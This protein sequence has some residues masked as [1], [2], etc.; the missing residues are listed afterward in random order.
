MDTKFSTKCSAK[1]TNRCRNTRRKWIT[2]RYSVSIHTNVSTIW[3]N[4]IDTQPANCQATQQ[5]KANL[6]SGKLTNYVYANVSEWLTFRNV[7]PYGSVK[8]QMVHI[9]SLG[10]SFWKTRSVHTLHQE[11]LLTAKFIC[12]HQHQRKFMRLNKNQNGTRTQHHDE[13]TSQPRHLTIQHEHRSES[14]GKRRLH[15]ARPATENLKSSTTWCE[16]QDR[17]E[18]T[19][20]RWTREQRKWTDPDTTATARAANE[21]TADT[22]CW[23]TRVPNEIS[24]PT[25]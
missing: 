17:R 18:P 20:E 12:N 23:P 16:Y 4:N 14:G 25:I 10:I 11:R 7:S 21:G 6:K 15:R 2:Q 3:D 8:R 5:R 19:K 24:S 1:V 9:S 22:W 13:N